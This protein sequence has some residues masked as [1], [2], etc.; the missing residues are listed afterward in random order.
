M[1]KPRTVPQLCWMIPKSWQLSCL[2]PCFYAVP[3][4]Q[5]AGAHGLWQVISANPRAERVTGAAEWTREPGNTQGQRTRGS[6]CCRLFGTS[7]AGEPTNAILQEPPQPSQVW[8]SLKKTWDAS[9]MLSPSIEDTTQRIVIFCACTPLNPN[10]PVARA[11]TMSCFHHVIPGETEVTVQQVIRKKK[12]KGIRTET[13]SSISLTTHSTALV[14][15]P[16]TAD[17]LSYRSSQ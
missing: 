17:D 12:I 11:G 8:Q 9:R 13:A 4:D 3:A 16:S 14:R 1:K 7:W 5:D 6:Q 15:N 10:P 2:S